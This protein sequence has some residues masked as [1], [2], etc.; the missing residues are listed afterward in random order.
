[1]VR[2]LCLSMISV[3]NMLSRVYKRRLADNMTTRIE[4]LLK[5]T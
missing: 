5:S 1:M 2:C 3:K 4:R